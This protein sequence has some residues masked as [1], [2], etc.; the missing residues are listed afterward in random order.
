VLHTLARL[1]ALDL[2]PAPGDWWRPGWP[3]AMT[4]AALTA[5]GHGTPRLDTDLRN[6]RDRSQRLFAPRRW[7]SGDPVAYTALAARAVAIAPGYGPVAALEREI[8]LAKCWTA[9]ELLAGVTTGSAHVPAATVTYLRERLPDWIRA[10]LAI[11]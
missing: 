2:T 9:V 1:H 6:V 8:A 4:D 7:I 11:P 5:L 10:I 3:E